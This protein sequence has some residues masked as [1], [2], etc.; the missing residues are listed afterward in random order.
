PF[1]PR[2]CIAAMIA[3]FFIIFIARPVGFIMISVCATWWTLTRI[4]QDRRR[5]KLLATLTRTHRFDRER[6]TDN[7]ATRGSPTGEANQRRMAAWQATKAA[8]AEEHDRLCR[9][10]DEG[11]L[12]ELAA[13]KVIKAA[14]EAEY[15][16]SCKEV[17]SANH[18]FIAAWEAANAPWIEE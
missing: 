3:G 10:A 7:R 14:R 5:E 17:D 6:T 15:E 11:N 12:R 4:T 1:L 18:R 9:K 8:L 2:L 13:W 16:R